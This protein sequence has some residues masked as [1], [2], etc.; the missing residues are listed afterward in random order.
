MGNILNNSKPEETE[1][2]KKEQ[3]ES[4]K[5]FVIFLA[6][7][8]ICVVAYVIYL[9]FEIV[10]FISAIL[11]ASLTIYTAPDITDKLLK[12]PALAYY[13]IILTLTL[14]LTIKQYK[15]SNEMMMLLIAH[16]LVSMGV[17]FADNYIISM[18]FI[19]TNFYLVLKIFCF[20]SNNPLSIGEIIAGQE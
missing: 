1:I 10:P 7:L 14:F 12:N 8:T 17:F 2:L 3:S 6:L 20:F 9:T 4:K 18:V 13:S 11:F 19:F 16:I 15:E 5:G